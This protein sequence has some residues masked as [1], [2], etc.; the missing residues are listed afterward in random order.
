VC[1]ATLSAWVLL[2]RVDLFLRPELRGSSPLAC[3][4]GSIRVTSRRLAGGVDAAVEAIRLLSGP[5]QRMLDLTGS[6]LLH[7]LA[8]RLGPGRLDVVSPGIFLSDDEEAAFVARLAARPPAV[9]VWPGR[10]FDQRSDR[11][12]ERFAPRLA[13]WVRA[14]YR[15]A[16]A[17][18]RYRILRPAQEPSR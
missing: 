12:L 9:V 6:P 2:Q 16:A 18:D 10:D 5:D 7:P 11:S 15:E 3:T 4:G 14:N 13:S 17:A 1:V 8:G